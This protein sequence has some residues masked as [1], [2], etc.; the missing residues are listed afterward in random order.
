[1]LM[2]VEAGAVG[3]LAVQDRPPFMIVKLQY[4]DTQLQSS[5]PT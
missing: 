1:M 2:G 4:N 5:T 3:Q